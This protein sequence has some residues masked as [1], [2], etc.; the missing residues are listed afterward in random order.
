MSR[1]HVRGAR[2]RLQLPLAESQS[3][4]ARCH[5]SSPSA[6]GHPQVPF[7]ECQSTRAR[8][9]KSSQS[10]SR[11]VPEYPCEVPQVVIKYLLQSARARCHKSSPSTFCRVPVRGAT[12]RPQV[13]FAEVPVRGA[14]SRPQVPFAECPGEVPQ[15][16]TKYLLQKCPGEVP[17]VVTKYL[18]QSARARCHKSSINTSSRMLEF[19]NRLPKT[20]VDFR[21]FFLDGL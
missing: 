20:G 7:S 5:K 21:A 12:S 13:P 10:T 9:H 3:T 1:A 14:T 18:L 17:Q 19:P 2:S 15:V 6:T 4:R 8:Y 16:V 11:S